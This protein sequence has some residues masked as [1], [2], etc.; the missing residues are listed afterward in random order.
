MSVNAVLKEVLAQTPCNCCS[1]TVTTV[2]C[3]F[4]NSLWILKWRHLSF[5]WRFLCVSVASAKVL[6]PPDCSSSQCLVLCTLLFE[7]GTFCAWQLEVSYSG[8]VYYFAKL[9]LHCSSVW[10]LIHWIDYYG[11]CFPAIFAKAYAPS[12]RCLIVEEGILDDL[13]LWNT[14]HFP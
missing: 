9:L 3:G 11:K 4:L 14:V 10:S 13:V 12:P 7:T 8:W 6:C 2:C 1:E 5:Q